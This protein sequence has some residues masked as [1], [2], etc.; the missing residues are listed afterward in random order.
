MLT[1]VRKKILSPHTIGLEVPWPGTG[2]FHLTFCVSLQVSGGLAVVET[3]AAIG[4][5]HAG[6]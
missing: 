2:T 5:R 3:P 4:P 6:Q 1:A